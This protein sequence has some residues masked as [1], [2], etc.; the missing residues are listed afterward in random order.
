MNPT[1]PKNRL[2]TSC[3]FKKFTCHRCISIHLPIFSLT[4]LLISRP[5]RQP[6]T[7]SKQTNKKA[8]P[9]RLQPFH[10]CANR[11]PQTNDTLRK[12]GFLMSQKNGLMDKK[13]L[14]QG[15]A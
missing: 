4:N 13:T 6:E 14:S 3:L 15:P 12:P 11:I 8:K 1:P 2:P 9:Y 10:V 5:S 7:P